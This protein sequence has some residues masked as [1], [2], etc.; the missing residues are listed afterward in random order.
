[1][2]LPQDDAIIDRDDFGRPLATP[3]NMRQAPRGTV[4]LDPITG[5]T[6]SANA[7]DYY[8]FGAHEA[9]TS[10]YNDEPLVLN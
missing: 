4:A 1:V 2:A 8:L 9:L 7:D 10:R 6:F 5:D 3:Y